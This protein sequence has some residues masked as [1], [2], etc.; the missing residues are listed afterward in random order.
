MSRV[1]LI[2]YTLLLLICRFFLSCPN[3]IPPNLKSTIYCITLREGGDTEWNF[4]YKQYQETT[5]ASEKEV[6]LSA[7]GCT[8]K[9]YLLN[10]YGNLKPFKFLDH[11]FFLNLCPQILELDNFSRFSHQKARRSPR[12]RS[13]R[14]EHRRFG[15]RF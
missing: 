12:F 8:Q 6:I 7:L 5:S 9:P 15:N 10:K 2:F 13:S 1:F 14:S 3:R 11:K 4:A